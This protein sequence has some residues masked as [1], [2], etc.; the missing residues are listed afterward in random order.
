MRQQSSWGSRSYDAVGS[1]LPTP[2]FT[3]HALLMPENVPTDAVRYT[4]EMEAFVEKIFRYFDEDGDAQLDAKEFELLVNE[5]GLQ[6][7][8]R[9]IAELFRRYQAACDKT[10]T[11]DEFALLFVRHKFLHET[12]PS[13]SRNLALGGALSAPSPKPL[14]QVD[15][16][17][18]FSDEKERR[19]ATA[20]RWASLG[21]WWDRQAH[22]NKPLKDGWAQFP[23]P[24]D[25]P[26]FHHSRTGISSWQP[27][28]ATDPADLDTLTK[29]ITAASW[30]KEEIP[31]L[32]LDDFVRLG[33]G[34]FALADGWFEYQSPDGAA[35]FYAHVDGRVQLERP[36]GHGALLLPPKPKSA[37]P[38]LERADVGRRDLPVSGVWGDGAN[39]R[40][41]NWLTPPQES[42]HARLRAFYE[43]HNPHKLGQVDAI[44][45]RV[46]GDE[47]L[48]NDSLFE[49]YGA[50]L[51]S[52]PMSLADLAA[53]PLRP[54]ATRD[55]GGFD[56][57]GGPRWLET[58]MLSPCGAVMLQPS[59]AYEVDVERGEPMT[60]NVACFDLGVSSGDCMFAVLFLGGSAVCRTELVSGADPLV[61]MRAF[62]VG[63]R[64]AGPF[65]V[66]VHSVPRAHAHDLKKTTPLVRIGFAPVDVLHAPSRSLEFPIP[67]RG[68][69]YL[70]A[71]LHPPRANAMGGVV[72]RMAV[73]GLRA[74][75]AHLGSR[76][77]LSSFAQ[78]CRLDALGLAV[79][80][81][82]TRVARDS[83]A[84]VW[85]FRLPC[86]LFAADRPA[87]S[88]QG[89]A[90]D[91]ERISDKVQI[92]VFLVE[93]DELGDAAVDV[94]NRIGTYTGPMVFGD[95][96]VQ[97]TAVPPKANARPNQLRFSRKDDPPVTG[98][99]TCMQ[100]TCTRA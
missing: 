25:H 23:G 64:S 22:T 44:V 52:S 32:V 80:V 100:L 61:F 45:A 2:L 51:G 54:R 41:L 28:A 95:G 55:G 66:E 70:T 46:A 18:N 93:D 5:L 40:Q 9:S 50:D 56:G 31:T 20:T 57:G 37:P 15:W 12:G 43:Q 10:L 98:A 82:Y 33:G 89:E 24:N 30:F 67:K 96:T 21:E 38:G 63:S 60:V 99:V 74:L 62:A 65:T 19:A 69:V 8:R 48:L 75:G 73:Q 76:K 47:D 14:L 86:H 92:N 68:S 85:T 71:A 35:R 49:L 39:A 81:M 27:P 17:G 36:V 77:R 3:Q 42:L 88:R 83:D 79:P 4:P 97:L 59:T 6:L 29:M 87:M 26:F 53:S 7:D 16:N 1:R 72:V 58:H 90:A 78:L 34:R 11:R 91:S 84:P 13:T 94:S